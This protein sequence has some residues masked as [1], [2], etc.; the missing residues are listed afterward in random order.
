M[1][2]VFKDNKVSIDQLKLLLE[3]SDPSEN[4]YEYLRD[5]LLIKVYTAYENFLKQLLIS[6]FKDAKI[7]YR[8]SPFLVDHKLWSVVENVGKSFI[9]PNGK[10][11]AINKNFPLLKECYFQEDLIL[12][13]NLVQERNKYAHTGSHGLTVEAIIQAYDKVN[14]LCGYLDFCYTE[15]KPDTLTSFLKVQS[16]LKNIK[17]VSPCVLKNYKSNQQIAQDMNAF[18]QTLEE[19]DDLD[20]SGIFAVHPEVERILHES[21]LDFILHC[22]GKSSNDFFYHWENYEKSLKD[23]FLKTM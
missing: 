1:N 9:V 17:K 4:V 15:L 8:Y 3:K 10:M 23:V 21:D 20:D 7:N 6:L 16:F 18:D 11:E 13:D 5:E 2:T 22:K 12:I 14:Y 19:F